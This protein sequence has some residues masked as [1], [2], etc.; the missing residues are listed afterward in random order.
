MQQILYWYRLKN[1]KI[2][3]KNQNT[4]PSFYVL[5]QNRKT[6]LENCNHL[7]RAANLLR[8]LPTNWNN[9]SQLLFYSFWATAETIVPGKRTMG[10]MYVWIICHWEEKSYKMQMGNSSS[11]H[12]FESEYPQ[13]GLIYITLK[14]NAFTKP[15]CSWSDQ[16]MLALFYIQ[17]PWRV[18][19]N[20]SERW[21]FGNDLR[22]W[23]RSKFRWAQ[24]WC[25]RWW[26]S[27]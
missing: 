17:L 25:S 20:S 21:Y 23:W 2:C 9:F 16:F 12:I 24:L 3:N 26:L 6:F 13:R 10:K 5:E 7:G 1:P 22:E 27:E 14:S 8:S 4:F 15:V 18:L 11:K 19:Q